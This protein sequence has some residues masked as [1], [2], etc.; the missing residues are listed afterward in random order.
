MTWWRTS[1]VL[2]AAAAL[3]ALSGA[4][5]A[6]AGG[7][8]TITFPGGGSE[9]YYVA[10][11]DQVNEIVITAVPGGYGVD[12]VVPISFTDASCRYPSPADTTLVQCVRPISIVDVD[13]G[14]LSDTIDNR[15]GV[16]SR[17]N[18]GDGN[19]TIVLGPPGLLVGGTGFRHV[20][21]G[22]AGNDR[23]VATT[24]T[25]DWLVGGRDF[26]TISYVDR[27]APVTV[28]LASSI[29][30]ERGESDG[31]FGFEAI[32]G[33]TAADTLTGTDDKNWIWGR[34][35]DDRI[36]GGRGPDTLLGEYGHDTLVG[37]PDN[38]ALH[39]GPGVDSLD[40]GT[41]FDSCYVGADG[42]WLVPGTCEY[43]T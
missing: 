40:G 22:G 5:P 19:D 39:G 29:G 30:G 23:I 12:D 1:A 31:L 13:A 26:D 37:G 36:T 32:E 3:V 33:G 10:G 21:G 35:G 24:R 4:A 38:D 8:A 34:D 43:V 16:S 20:A 25:Q 6:Y 18:G 2:A 9:M 14:R 42:A 27:A 17:L 28:N 11:D 41:E 15:A 7:V